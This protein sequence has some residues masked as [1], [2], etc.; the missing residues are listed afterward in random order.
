MAP[1]SR[2][3]AGG[4]EEWGSTSF[5]AVNELEHPHRDAVIPSVRR[6]EG[7]A[8]R[9]GAGAQSGRFGQ[10]AA[11]DDWR[12]VLG[13]QR[14]LPILHPVA[15]LVGLVASIYIA[16]RPVAMQRALK[17]DALAA[18]LDGERIFAAVGHPIA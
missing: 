2:R 10:Q 13:D 18:A 12:A 7:E 6:G 5:D 17:R 8:I 1:W 14:Q 3:R 9:P 4:R 16:L 11:N 15:R